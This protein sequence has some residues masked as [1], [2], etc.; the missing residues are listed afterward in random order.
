[1]VYRA[2][3]PQV[4][5]KRQQ[6]VDLLGRI[7]GV[8]DAEECVGT[9]VDA[10]RTFNYRNKMEFSVSTREWTSLQPQARAAEDTHEDTHE[11]TQED[12]PS[13]KTARATQ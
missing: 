13:Q 5:W 9:L 2:L 8:A 7:G 6:V 1:M 4:R 11:D 12:A 3:W 10:A